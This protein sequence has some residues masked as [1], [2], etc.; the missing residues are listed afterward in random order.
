MKPIL[1]VVLMLAIF[2]GMSWCVPYLNGQNV[3]PITLT[4]I[5]GRD[6]LVDS[7]GNPFFAHGITHVGNVRAKLNFEEVSRACKKL[8][9]NAYG[10]GC[11]PELRNDMPY[12]ESWNHLVPISTYRGDGSFQFVD[13]FD[14]EVQAKI[15]KGIKANCTRSR[16]NPNVLHSYLR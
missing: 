1:K 4:K 8:G 14:P 3:Q 13:I 6:W 15:V 10:Y 12:I 5:E 11:P 7:A 2:V 16:Q 9:F